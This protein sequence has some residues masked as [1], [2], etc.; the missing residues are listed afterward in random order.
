[1]CIVRFF[2]ERVITIRRDYPMTDQ[3]LL[4]Q[5]ADR[6]DE[7]AFAEL[8][9][10]HLNWVHSAALRQVGDP[11][12][13]DDVA[14]AVFIALASK[15][16][17]IPRTSPLSPWLF[18]A[19]RYACTHALRAASRRRFHE[20]E[21]AAMTVEQ[22][23]EPGD[24]QWTELAPHLDEQMGHLRASD[25]QA[26]LLRYFEGRGFTDIGKQLGITERSGAKADGSSRRTTQT[27]IEPKN[28]D[29]RGGGPGDSFGSI[30]GAAC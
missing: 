20:N 27:F 1:M 12:T 10:R 16:A 18:K 5:F 9:R 30:R 2:P 7:S 15:A 24:L 22:S 19:T 13:A 14:Q 26:I 28:P 4:T 23:P 6:Q 3:Q 11:H 29:R 21:A 8:V 17:K 25:R